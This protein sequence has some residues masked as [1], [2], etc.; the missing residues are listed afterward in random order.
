LTGKAI[1]YARNQWDHLTRYTGDGLAPIDNNGSERHIRPFC[2][3]RKSWL[4]SDTVAGA[5]ASAVIYSLVLTCR[6]CG[7]DPYAWLR[8]AL[9]EMPKRA[10]DADIEDLLPFNCTAQKN[11]PA[12]SDSG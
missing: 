8:H 10:P 1:A 9:T 12:D 3:G 2:T 11:L 5:K 4:F 6:A 7:V